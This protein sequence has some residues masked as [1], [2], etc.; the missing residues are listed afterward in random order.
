M[1]G[2]SAL[3]LIHHK[4]MTVSLSKGDHHGM[5][6]RWG[7]MGRLSAWSW[8][9]GCVCSEA[10]HD[11]VYSIVRG[12]RMWEGTRRTLSAIRPW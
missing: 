11:Q 5:D 8:I 9:G 3:W 6:G 7:R 4:A 2:E 1:I 12:E 10:G